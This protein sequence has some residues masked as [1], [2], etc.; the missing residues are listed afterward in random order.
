M[1]TFYTA[2]AEWADCIIGQLS[3]TA[4]SYR[5]T[6]ITDAVQRSM[7]NVQRVYDLQGRRVVSPTRAGLYVSNG[8]K[9][10]VR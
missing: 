9:V 3:L 8:K 10:M 4:D 2:A 1:F 5:P 6:G 7:F